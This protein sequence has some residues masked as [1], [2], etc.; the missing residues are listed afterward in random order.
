MESGLA[1]NFKRLETATRGDDVKSEPWAS[2]CSEP[3]AILCRCACP[4]IFACLPS[5][6]SS[7]H[8]YWWRCI[9][10][11]SIISTKRC[12]TSRP[13]HCLRSR[14][15]YFTDLGGMY[16]TAKTPGRRTQICWSYPGILGSSSELQSCCCL[17]AAFFSQ[18]LYEQAAFEA[19]FRVDQ[20]ARMPLPGR[21]S[22]QAPT[23]QGFL[24]QLLIN[25][26]ATR[27][28]P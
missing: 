9:L 10:T 25:N 20:N 13:L 17:S 16:T 6:S 27:V 2:V 15:S 24:M 3:C 28:F 11:R 5:F 18:G 21:S 22:F 23:D 14:R 1:K 7:H 8:R 12:I 4:S 26:R 19:A